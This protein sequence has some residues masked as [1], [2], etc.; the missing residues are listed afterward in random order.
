MTRLIEDTTPI[1][2]GLLAIGKGP[3]GFLACPYIQFLRIDGTELADSVI[4]EAGIGGTLVDRLH[5]SEERFT[6]H[7]R[8][9]LDITSAV[10]HKINKPYH[11]LHGNRFCTMPF[12]TEPT[13][14]PTRLF[15][16][17]GFDDRIEINSPGGPYGNVT[18]ESLG[19]PS[20]ARLS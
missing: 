16:Y 12:Y 19:Q 10:T 18:P 2:T 8:A 20:V 4:D 11:P 15:K 1:I 17:T 3:Q 13:Q 9:T 14:A 5:R 6:A 7:P